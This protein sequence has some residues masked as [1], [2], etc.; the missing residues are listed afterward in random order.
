MLAEVPGWVSDL[1]VAAGTLTAVILL[2]RHLVEQ[3]DNRVKHHIEPIA[4]KVEG[5]VAEMRPNS[6]TS[7]RDRVDSVHRKTKR[8]EE[9]QMR[10]EQR[11]TVVE[12]DRPPT[13]EFP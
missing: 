3:V 2:L 6:G 7:L 10:F 12:A 4:T 13:K 1:G 11:L 9:R 8:I 5:L